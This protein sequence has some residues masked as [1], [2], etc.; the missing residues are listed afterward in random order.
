MK[1]LTKVIDIPTGH[2]VYVEQYVFDPSWDT[3]L[4]V[5]GALSTTESFRQTIKYMR[6]RVNVVAYDLPY[7]GKS[8]PHNPSTVTL[9]SDEE[10]RIL[11]ALIERFQP[12][13]LASISWGGVST[14]RALALQP[15]SVKSAIVASFSPLLNPA[16]LAYITQAQEHLE[17]GR[18]SDAAQ[19]LNDTV[20]R[21][22]P[23][24]LKVSNHRYMSNLSQLQ[25]DQMV[26]HIRQMRNLP[27]Q[28]YMTTLQNINVPVLFMNGELDDYT[29]A[30]DIHAVGH[31]VRD[32]RFLTVKDAGHFL[33]MENR[34]VWEDV[35]RI[36]LTFMADPKAHLES[37]PDS[38]GAPDISSSDAYANA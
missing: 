35:K 5:N 15:P 13:H 24:I 17:A 7:Y 27:V 3:V 28:E 26:F 38:A 32:S 36:V 22:L 20:G 6:E 2:K 9:T 30:E 11:S 4:L 18:Q 10:V 29:T 1:P 31:F 14:L 8:Q 33:D 25:Y 12:A 16:M 37:R 34:R 23:R 21:Y 19:L